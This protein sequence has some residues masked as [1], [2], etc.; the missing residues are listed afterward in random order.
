MNGL[1]LIVF[2]AEAG[3]HAETNGFL[4]SHN[5][6]EV[7]WSALASVIVLGFLY[8]KGAPVARTA[9]HA[10]TERI[11]REIEE[12]DRT[13]ADAETRLAE[14]Q[15]RV[16]G[17][18]DERQ[19]ILV[20]ARQT[21]EALKQQI[22]ARAEE[23]AQAAAARAAADVEAARHQAIADLQ[24]EVAT[25]ALGAAEAIVARNLDAD[26]QN[27]LIDGYIEQLGAQAAA[28]GAET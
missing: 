21:A 12:A 11:A 28:A 10:R 19:R 9:L 20:E 18:E 14:V 6:T 5:V 27:E 17:A 22:V 8:W 24:A 23:E 16:G 2:A 13:Q 1:G 15:S 3:G 26:T 4:L 25:L 7:L